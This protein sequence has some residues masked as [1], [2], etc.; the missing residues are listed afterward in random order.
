MVEIDDALY[1]GA[2]G[3]VVC[4]NGKRAA[5]G[6]AETII[7]LELGFGQADELRDTGGQVTTVQP[8]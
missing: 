6:F 4:G 5:L 1:V 2:Q 7:P 3:C 8:V